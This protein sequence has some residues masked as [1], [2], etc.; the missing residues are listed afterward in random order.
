MLTGRDFET[1]GKVA[2]E[3]YVT[4]K[5]PL[6]DTITKI[7]EHYGLNNEQISRVVES[8]NVETYLKLNKVQDDKY[9]EF[10][11]AEQTKIASALTFE[12]EKT[13]V[14]FEESL[15]L[16]KVA[17]DVYSIGELDE[18]AERIEESEKLRLE[19]VAKSL[20]RLIGDRLEEVDTVFTRESENLYKLVK[21]A[22]LESGSFGIVKQAM[23]ATS[24]EPSVPLIIDAF[25]FKLEK[26]GAAIDFSDV[27]KPH[28]ILNK[29]HPL[30]TSL[31]KMSALKED[32]IKLKAAQAELDKEAGVG[33]TSLKYIGDILK[34]IAGLT[35]T[36]VGAGL[37]S[38]ATKPGLAV[39]G[40][41]AALG[42]A[43]K[44]G[45]TSGRTE[46][47]KVNAKVNPEYVQRTKNLKPL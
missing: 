35:G 27:D 3:R 22:S 8:A 31:A 6:N 17:K 18:D 9:I 23:L 10:P 46:S 29:D 26:E 42:G 5:K 13:A 34:S 4:S 7:A 15:L 2:A 24:E 45:K 47:S 30:V 11:P 41:A 38:A 12:A 40:T 16:D 1:M 19:K 44:I 36:V 32:Y 33:I 39:L 37:R 25:K 28:G 43:Y 20:Q 14:A 21:Q